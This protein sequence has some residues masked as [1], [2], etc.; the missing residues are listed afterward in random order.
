MEEKDNLLLLG[1]RVREIKKEQK[2]TQAQLAEK[3]DLSTNFIGMVERGK[4][5]TTIDKMYKIIEALGVSCAKF[6]EKQ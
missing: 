1:S 2:L 3:I 5:N 4:R 6:Y